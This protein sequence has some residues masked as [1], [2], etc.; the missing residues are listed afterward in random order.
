MSHRFLRAAVRGVA[1][2]AIA[3][4]ACAAACAH[5]H[6]ST[7]PNTPVTADSIAL[8]RLEPANPSVGVG[9][10]VPLVATFLDSAGVELNGLTIDWISDHIS[11]A[12]VSPDGVVTGVALG[13]ATI[14]AT[15]LGKSGETIVHVVQAAVANVAVVPSSITIGINKKSQLTAIVTDAQ[16]NVLDGRFVS[17]SSSNSAVNV[18]FT[19]LVI[20]NATGTATITAQCEG[21][22]GSATVVVVQGG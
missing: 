1:G 15:S 14:T 3:L 9:L 20:G 21:W 13:T 6:A 16:G 2:G 8:V 10:S 17:W 19:G 12:R 11:V 7:Q 5:D 18:D 22:Q 4:A